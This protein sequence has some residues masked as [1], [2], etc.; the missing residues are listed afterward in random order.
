[1]FNAGDWAQFIL[2]SKGTEAAVRKRQHVQD[3]ISRRA[4][5]AE[6]LALLGEL[7]VGRWAFEGATNCL[8]NLST[9]RALTNPVRRCS[10]PREPSHL[11]HDVFLAYLRLA[12]RGAGAIGVMTRRPVE[13]LYWSQSCD[14]EVQGLAQRRGSSGRLGGNPHGTDDSSEEGRWWCPGDCGRR[15]LPKICRVHHRTDRKVS[16]GCNVAFP[17]CLPT[18]GQSHSAN[19]WTRC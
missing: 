15:F 7:S 9:L 16:G 5:R 11:D 6:R 18:K 14:S 17:M 13:A 2:G 3:D 1:M 4:A 10:A 8:C 12:R 19:T